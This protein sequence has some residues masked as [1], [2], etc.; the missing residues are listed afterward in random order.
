MLK[1][2]FLG[3]T[4]F[5]LDNKNISKQISNKGT[6]LVLILMIKKEHRCNRRELYSLLW[7]KSEEEAARYNL[8]YNLW[9]IKKLIPPIGAEKIHFIETDRDYVFLNRAY[10]FRCD[11]MEILTTRPE[12]IKTLDQMEHLE[13]LFQGDL[14]AGSSF[15]G[16]DELNELVI[17]QQ[18]S[19]ENKQLVLLEKLV[20]FYYENNMKRQC[21][22]ILGK[23][24]RLDPYDENNAKIH[25]KLLL[26]DGRFSEVTRFYQQFTSM[27]A[28][29][30]GLMPS[31]ELKKLVEG[32]KLSK[33]DHL[34]EPLLQI[35]VDT[36]GEIDGYLLSQIVGQMLSQKLVNLEDF[37]SSAQIGDLAYI[38]WRAGD[39]PKN[40]SSMP[41]IVEAFC[42]LIDGMIA[43]GKRLQISINP[44][45]SPDRISKATLHMLAKKHGQSFLFHYNDHDRKF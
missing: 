42:A 29:D 30:I 13:A 17:M 31:D 37:L 3:E 2:Q 26:E 19:L 35:R 40:G 5:V 28:Q 20:K 38:Q 41:R 25:M 22:A 43:A 44:G 36:I 24:E 7:P 14:L 16:C 15:P 1:I 39:C 32:I 12:Q 4:K 18:Y 33:V 23:C 11:L 34:S 10:P 6:A 9:L 27:L 45:C 8:R 21:L